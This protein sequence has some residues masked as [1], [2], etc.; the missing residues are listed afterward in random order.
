VLWFLVGGLLMVAGILVAG[1]GL[2]VTLPPV[3]VGTAWT[4][5]VLT[6]HAVSPKED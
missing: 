4:Y 5:R 1:V 2:L 6:G 3:L